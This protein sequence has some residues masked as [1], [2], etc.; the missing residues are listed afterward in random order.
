M[1]LRLV[2]LLG[3]KEVD[4]CGGGK[5]KIDH[6]DS[7]LVNRYVW[8]IERKGHTS[9]AVCYLDPSD[10]TRCI[11]MH[12]LIMQPKPDEVVDHIDGNGLNNQR[13]NL[14]I[15][16]LAENSRN[17]RKS[18]GRSSNYK[19][20]TKT[21]GRKK[22]WK[23]QIATGA[24]VRSIGYFATEEEAAR[25]YDLAAVDVFGQFACLNFPAVARNDAGRKPTAIS[26]ENELPG[27]RLSPSI[28]MK[29]GDTNKV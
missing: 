28:P 4:L 24:K 13:F 9:Y 7:D 17:R 18:P 14:R 19:G 20:V 3:M 23:A 10:L 16:T 1:L 11:R 27:V 29:T 26:R 6:S 22:C 12:R 15:C 8:S 21:T 25:A 2:E 5:A